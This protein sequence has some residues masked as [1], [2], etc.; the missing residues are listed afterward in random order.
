MEG[1][2]DR[3]P[4]EQITMGSSAEELRFNAL[5]GPPSTARTTSSQSSK[6]SRLRGMLSWRPLAS[7]R[8]EA[9]TEGTRRGRQGHQDPKEVYRG[10]GQISLQ[11]ALNHV[12]Q[13]K[14][15]L[16]QKWALEEV[17][18]Q[19]DDHENGDDRRT[20]LHWAAAR[21]HLRCIHLLLQAGASK[22]VRDRHGQT[23]AELA[24]A[25]HQPLAHDLLFYGL[26]KPDPRSVHSEL[27]GLSIHAA[28]NQPSQLKSILRNGG[29]RL[30]NPDRYDA[31]G[32]SHT[33]ATHAR[34][35]EAAHAHARGIHP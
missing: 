24:M 26:P 18:S 30:A 2:L 35:H 11:T 27:Y 21:G 34:A 28:L 7:S 20:P 9:A 13:L 1:I 33:R 32:T 16:N 3:V 6:S 31:D 19:D 4:A 5:P 10:L 8:G 29:E 23:P 22:T 25:V 12:A 15:M 17:N 14:H